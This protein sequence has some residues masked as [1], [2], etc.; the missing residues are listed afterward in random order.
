[1]QTSPETTQTTSALIP[2]NTAESAT[3]TGLLSSGR[4]RNG[5]V[6]RLPKEIRDRIN[7]MLQ[8]GTPY[9]DVIQQLG[10]DGQSLNEDNIRTWK[11]GG[12]LD[13]LGQQ[14]KI[15]L[16]RSRQEFAIDLV[17]EKDTTKIHQATLQIAAANLCELLI[18]LDPIS[19]RA[20][21]QEEPDKYTRLLNAIVRLSDGQL[22]AE[23]FNA[24]AAEKQA[25]LAKAREPRQPGGIS[26][27]ALQA[28]EAKLRLL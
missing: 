27:E 3:A 23:R 1:M 18:D 10:P 14:Q 13:W 28:A 17:R 21:I 2:T 26:D 6:A 22:K 12:Y 19:L 7:Q 20:M 5:K 4:T 11:A 9:L 15:D 8:D 16:L 24:D 25:A